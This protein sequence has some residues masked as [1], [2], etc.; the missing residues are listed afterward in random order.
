MLIT[1]VFRQVTKKLFLIRVMQER[2]NTNEKVKDAVKEMPA[3]AKRKHAGFSFLE[4]VIAMAIMAV[5]G[6]ILFPKVTGYIKKAR[7]VKYMN[8]AKT[9]C[10]AVFLYLLE[11]DEQGIHPEGWELAMDICVPFEEDENH[12]LLSYIEG[13]P[14][15]DG[16]LYSIFYDGTLESYEGIL[17][18]AGGYSIEARMNGTVEFAD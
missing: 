10:E 17:Y 2:M 9:V 14:S 12:P 5:M 18:D 8:E 16:F 13:T 1:A 6:A 7:E 11:L 15:E 4:I 3:V